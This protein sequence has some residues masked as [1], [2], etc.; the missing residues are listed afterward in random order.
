MNLGRYV[1]SVVASLFLL[2]FSA[3]NSHASVM[4]Q[5]AAVSTTMG[6]LGGSG[7]LFD[8]S[9]LVSQVGLTTPYT[10]GVTDAATYSSTHANS[11][12]EW[13]AGPGVTTGFVSFDLGSVVGVDG[14][15]LWNSS[16]FTGPGPVDVNQFTLFADNDFDPSNGLGASLGTFTATST[17][18][19]HPMQSFSFGTA[20][21]RYIQMQIESNHGGAGSGFAEAA[22]TGTT[23]TVPEPSILALLGISLAGMGFA[24]KKA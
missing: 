8:V 18:A 12:D 6:Q 24:R 7:G 22:F 20:S 9:Q 11:R 2:V 4:L 3:T 14:F 19:D 16:W 17:E 13:Q 1:S 5:P 21:T 10:S 23:G 15:R